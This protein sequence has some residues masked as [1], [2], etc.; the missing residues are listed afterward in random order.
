MCVL[1]NRKCNE[2]CFFCVDCV[3]ALS[4][5]I[6][7]VN[8]GNLKSKNSYQAQLF[9]PQKMQNIHWKTYFKKSNSF[10]FYWIFSRL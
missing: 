2:K 1:S 4:T 6:N 9:F 10:Y 8:L 5:R 3:F 7:L